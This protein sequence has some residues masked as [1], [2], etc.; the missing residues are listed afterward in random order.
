MLGKCVNAELYISPACFYF[1]D[2]KKT[3]CKL[4]R[5]ALGDGGH[6]LVHSNICIQ[7]KDK[8]KANVHQRDSSLV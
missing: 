1:L 6:R 2:V 5:L 3:S 4:P 7:P 8:N